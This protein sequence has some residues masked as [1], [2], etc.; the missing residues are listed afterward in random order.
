MIKGGNYLHHTRE[1]K[2][3]NCIVVVEEIEGAMSR[4]GFI[5]T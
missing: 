4:K 2:Q 5:S 3:G 1:S